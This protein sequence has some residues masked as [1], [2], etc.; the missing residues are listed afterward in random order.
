[1]VWDGT[2]DRGQHVSSGMYFYKL[3]SGKYT[4]TRKMMLLK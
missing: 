3:V 2:N 1:V 4:Q